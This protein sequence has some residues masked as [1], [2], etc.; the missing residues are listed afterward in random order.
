MTHGTADWSQREPRC[1]GSKEAKALFEAAV[2]VPREQT[3]TV[4]LARVV[5]RHRRQM[6]CSLLPY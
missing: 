2:R 6:G 5:P 4:A 1:C 3:Y